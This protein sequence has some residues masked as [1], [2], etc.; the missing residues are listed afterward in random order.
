[1][2]VLTGTTNHVAMMLPSWSS[3]W[4]A[5]RRFL[6]SISNSFLTTDLVFSDTLISLENKSTC[7]HSGKGFAILVISGH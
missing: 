6:G 2:N 7:L 1:V 4:V 5:V 3:T